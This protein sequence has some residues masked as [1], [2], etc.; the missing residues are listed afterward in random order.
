[1]PHVS[2]QKLLILLLPVF[3]AS[4]EGYSQLT[5]DFSI[6]KA[7][8]CSPLTVSFTNKTTGAGSG[9][10][11]QWDLGNGNTSIEKDP[12]AIYT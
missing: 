10:S 11:F 1:M 3:M 9:A 4:L 6:S 12:A 7:S 5:V 8:G 2:V